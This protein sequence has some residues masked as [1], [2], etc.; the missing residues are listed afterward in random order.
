MIGAKGLL[1][2]G[3][4]RIPISFG[5]C[6]IKAEASRIQP[7]HAMAVLQI[8]RHG[9]VQGLRCWSNNFPQPQRLVNRDPYNGLLKS[10]YTWVV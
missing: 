10:L 2:N 9:K 1:N 5:F 7:L 8:G 4:I 3:I 6:I